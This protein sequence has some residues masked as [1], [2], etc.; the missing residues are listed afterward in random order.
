[1]T[2]CWRELRLLMT[3]AFVI[4]GLALMFPYGALSFRGKDYPA[5][6]SSAAYVVL[7]ADESEAALHAAKSAWQTED[8]AQRR[9]RVRMPLGELPEESELEVL[10]L[11]SS[12]AY[13]FSEVKSV[14]YGAPAFQP[15]LAAERDSRELQKAPMTMKPAFS[16]D[17]LLQL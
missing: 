2:S 10:T 9:L 14:V 5:A 17:D 3:V 12:A 11:D 13:S 4:V 1:M 8:A 15:S 6:R 16:R 7:S